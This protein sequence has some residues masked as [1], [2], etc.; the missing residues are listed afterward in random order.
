MGGKDIEN[1]LSW[2]KIIIV[3]GGIIIYTC[4]LFLCPVYFLARRTRFEHPIL[5]IGLGFS[6][7]AFACLLM[8]NPI[9]LAF[10]IYVFSGTFS[11]LLF[12]RLYSGKWWGRIETSES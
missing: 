7:T 5:P 1:L 4:L 8:G 11:G 9:N 2:G 10:F 3:Y 6:V 12:W